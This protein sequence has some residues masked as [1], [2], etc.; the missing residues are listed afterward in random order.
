MEYTDAKEAL[1]GKEWKFLLLLLFS[2]ILIF[3]IH[4]S[5]LTDLL[6]QL[7]QLQQLIRHSGALGAVLYVSLF[8]VAALCL[9]PGS[10]LVIAGGM[11]FGPVYGTL[12]SVLA[13]TLA[14]SASFLL[15]RR[16][17]RNAL[18]RA[19]GHTPAFRRVEHGIAR[20][21]LDF[22]LLTRLIPLF[23]Y[24]LQNYAYGLTS[25]AFWPFTV[26]SAVTTLP[27]L[28]IYTLM[29]SELATQGI[30]WLF[31]LK[32]SVAGLLLFA[33]V[34]GAKRWA[35]SKGVELTDGTPL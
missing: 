11:I 21:G 5:G 3:V 20:H 14:S 15:A 12:L 18:V 1:T 26:I 2:G 28:L 8:V 35:K 9:M 27:G 32:L 6:L 31:T 7:Q 23:P 16:V 13:A 10:L 22:L 4:R 17:G 19:F 33:I 25:I 34:Q 29:A 30:S 24:T